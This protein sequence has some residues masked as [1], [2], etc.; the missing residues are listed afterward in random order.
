M[1]NFNDKIAVITGGGDGM[2]RSLAVQ[3]ANEGC[4]VALCDLGT[5][6]T[7]ATKEAC[8]A[9]GTGV[10]VTTHVCDVSDEAALEGFRDEIIDQHATDHVHLLFNNAGIGGGGSI[11]TDE[12]AAWE[13]TFNVCWGGVYL[14]TRVFLPLLMA[15]DDAHLVNT[16]SVN[17]FWASLGPDTSHTSYSAAKFA[18]KGFS[19]ALVT[20][21]RL[22]APHVKV[23]VVM[24][25]HI[26]TGIA[27]NSATAHGIEPDA[28]MIERGTMFRNTAPMTADEAATVIL[29]GVRAENWRILVGMDAHALDMAVRDAPE[30]AYQP[31]F[32]ARLAGHLAPLVG[33]GE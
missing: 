5:E 9:T 11:V 16:S 18:V 15:A 7:A 32:I 8:E 1:Q 30:E 27:L 14:G 26:G 4:H 24:P 20:D 21:L 25:G 3:L 13:R 19:E 33:D 12:R 10:L 22:T 28:E 2:G 31:D 6:A 29:D 23:S 17:G